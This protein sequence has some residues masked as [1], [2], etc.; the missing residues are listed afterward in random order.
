MLYRR[1]PY[2]WIYDGDQSDYLENL[3]WDVY[4][5]AQV[6]GLEAEKVRKFT[7]C[8]YDLKNI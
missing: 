1:K 3:G 7:H 4:Y 5:T 2:I 8:A 6:K